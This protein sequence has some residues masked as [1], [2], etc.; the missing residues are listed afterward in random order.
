MENNALIIPSGYL[1]QT[2]QTR[3]C[4][5]TAIFTVDTKSTTNAKRLKVLLKYAG[6]STTGEG[7]FA[8]KLRIM[9]VPKTEFLPESDFTLDECYQRHFEDLTFGGIMPG[10][11]ICG[12][13]FSQGNYDSDMKTRKED[14]KL[15]AV[16]THYVPFRPIDREGLEWIS[17]SD[18]SDIVME[19]SDQEIIK[20]ACDR[21][22]SD[23]LTTEA[24]Y[25]LLP[26][27]FSLSMVQSVYEMAL[28]VK[29]DMRNFTNKLISLP[30]IKRCD[31][32]KVGRNII[33]S[34]D[35]VAF[36][37]KRKKT[38]SISILDIA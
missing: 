3:I 8:K 34:F 12:I 31:D 18:L 26:T 13:S 25:Q 1:Y 27:Y 19:D 14:H 17:I 35:G 16:S 24:A 22:R 11:G 23:V 2:R 15:I 5:A 30:Y 10:S 20:A 28:G 33:Y 29:F 4:L 37:E 38:P 9:C 32:K 6:D 7:I 21:F 36:D